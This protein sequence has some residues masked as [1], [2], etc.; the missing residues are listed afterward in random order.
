[1]GRAARMLRLAPDRD[2]PRRSAPNIDR[3]DGRHGFSRCERFLRARMPRTRTPTIRSRDRPRINDRRW[4]PTPL[5]A[6]EFRKSHHLHRCGGRRFRQLPEPAP[7]R[8]NYGAES[9][10]QI[11][12]LPLR[13]CRRDSTAARS[14]DTLGRRSLRRPLSAC[15]GRHDRQYRSA[16]HRH[17]AASNALRMAAPAHRTPIAG[18]CAAARETRS[19]PAFR[20]GTC[21]LR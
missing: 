2:T 11:G 17:D 12:P 14:S 15:S 19:T 6:R 9:R 1:M 8:G 4:R 7:M 16:L 18:I 21:L 13:C 10:Q 20:R 3:P 5:S